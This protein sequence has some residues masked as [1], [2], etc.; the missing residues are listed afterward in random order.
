MAREIARVPKEEQL[1]QAFGRSVRLQWTGGSAAKPDLSRISS[2]FDA[3]GPL[4]AAPCN[5]RTPWIGY[6]P[7]C[8]HKRLPCNFSAVESD[9][10]D[11]VFSDLLQLAPVIIVNSEETKRDLV[12][13]Y[14]HASAEIIVLPF[15]AAPQPYWFE[16]DVTKLLSKYQLPPEYFL[17]SNQFWIHKNHAVIIEALAIAKAEARRHCVVF[18]GDTYDYR[19]PQHFQGLVRHAEDLGVLQNCY[20][21]GLL[22]K[23]DQIGLMRAAVGVIQPTLFEGGPGGGAVFDAVAMGKRIVLSDI[24]IN[25]EIERYVDEYFAPTDSRALHLAMCRA[26]QRSKSEPEEKI[27]LQEGHERRRKCGSVLK[28][29]FSLAVER[30]QQAVNHRP[31]S[32]STPLQSNF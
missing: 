27:L 30:T 11:R 9:K 28:S 23:S 10:R 32:C 6:I 29:A 2:A 12:N 22:P 8:Q 14:P 19:D 21:L 4:L 25:R 5:Q 17:C 26:E 1:R 24:P 16:I 13:Y 7:D 15:A 31:R 3:I 18:T 20:F